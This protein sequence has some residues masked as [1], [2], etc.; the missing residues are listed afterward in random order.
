MSFLIYRNSS[1]PSFFLNRFSPWPATHRVFQAYLHFP[2]KGW[3]FTHIPPH[4]AFFT[5][6]LGIKLMSP[7][8]HSKPFMGW[9][10]QFPSPLFLFSVISLAIVWFNATQQGN[11]TF[12]YFPGSCKELSLSV[13]LVWVSWVEVVSLLM[14]S[15]HRILP[16]PLPSP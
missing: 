15:E 5:W 16:L 10:S 7:C 13:F 14:C 1:Q 4:S 2:P 8:L 9:H 3:D 11:A 6:I 12:Q